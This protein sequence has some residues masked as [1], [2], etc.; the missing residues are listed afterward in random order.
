MSM[1]NNKQLENRISFLEKVI[2]GLIDNKPAT[3]TKC[4]AGRPRKS[5]KLLTISEVLDAEPSIRY[6]IGGCINAGFQKRRLVQYG[7]V[8]DK[9]REEFNKRGW[10][11]LTKDDYEN[12]SDYF[13]D[14]TNFVDSA[15]LKAFKEKLT[16][17][18]VYVK[19]EDRPF[20]VIDVLKTEPALKDC[21]GGCIYKAMKNSNYVKI[22]KI[23]DIYD[24]FEDLGW[25]KPL[26]VKNFDE[27][28]QD[29]EKLCEDMTKKTEEAIVKTLNAKICKDPAFLKP[30]SAGK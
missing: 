14:M 30:E 5:S 28:S 17:E 15:V 9:L 8:F 27:F 19:V 11:L 1:A 13:E 21:I 22:T 20:R 3:K 29:I 25:G 2:E 6:C 26:T 18:D 12:A 24:A 10:Q 23:Q 16:N 4:G 7:G